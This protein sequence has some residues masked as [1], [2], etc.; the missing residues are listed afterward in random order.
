MFSDII[1]RFKAAFE[2]ESVED[3][4]C[5]LTKDLITVF[6]FYGTLEKFPLTNSNLNLIKVIFF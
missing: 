3:L 5:Q 2:V 6:E 4:I 1:L